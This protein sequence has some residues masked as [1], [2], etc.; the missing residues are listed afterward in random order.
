MPIE[1]RTTGQV[2]RLGQACKPWCLFLAS[3]GVFF[4]FSLA[5]AE[6]QEEKDEQNSEQSSPRVVPPKLKHFEEAK[7]PEGFDIADSPKTVLLSLEISE[8]GTINKVEVLES[9]GPEFDDAAVYAA[10]GFVFEPARV[11]GKAVPVRIKYQYIFEIKEKVVKEKKLIVESKP[12]AATTADDEDEVD[13]FTATAQVDQ[14]REVTKRTIESEVLL[15][16]PGTRGDALR[17]VELLPGVGRPPFSLGQLIVRGAAPG[18]SQTQLESLPIPLL[19][20]FGGLTS[21]IQPRL[22]KQID[23]YPGN[24]S[25]RFG[26]RTGGILDVTLRDPKDDALHGM[27]DLNIID[28]SVMLEGPVGKKGSFAAAARRSYIDLVLDA[29][30]PEGDV[31]IVAAPVY[32]DYQGLFNYKVS[33][34]DQLRLLVYGSNDTLRLLFQDPS[35]GDPLI[36]GNFGIQTSFHKLQG[37]WIHQYSRRT[38]HR[39]DLSAG[40]VN[41][42]FNVGN[43]IS[44]NL[45]SVEILGRSEW[46]TT[47]TKRLRIISGLDIRLQPSEFAYTGAQPTQQEGDPGNTV[48]GGDPVST[49]DLITSKGNLFIYEPAAY[50]TLDLLP[51]DAL[52]VLLSLRLDYFGWLDRWVFDPRSVVRYNLTDDTVIKA[53]VGLYSQPPQPQEGASQLGNPGLLGIRSMHLSTGVEQKLGKQYEVGAEL[54]YKYLWDRVVGTVGSLPPYFTNDG[55]GRIYGLELSGKVNPGGNFFGFLSYTLSRSERRDR[56]EQWRLFDFDQTH[57]LTVSGSYK[58]GEGWEAGATFRLVTGNPYTPITAAIY[59]ANVDVYQPIYG[60][61]NTKRNPMFHRL[62]VRIEKQ[63]LFRYWKLAA[64]LDVQ[65]VYN[66]MNPE[67]ILYSFDYS[68]TGVVSGLPII[69]S[70]GM[71][72]EF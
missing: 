68:Q 50:L 48:G 20:H 36:Q 13:S 59:N 51:L 19:Y 4:Q 46:Q 56:G 26:R 17:A 72:G 32:W 35:E 27:A 5:A 28:A 10:M 31:S 16:V 71:R 21:V 63:W 67:G 1:S 3:F 66:R 49:Q 24:F 11:N 30:V 12:A 34:R 43:D 52:Q 15:K 37:S 39:I 62:D 9:A 29:V 8:L 57:I 65:N 54:F 42:A 69:P 44:F 55:T 64:Y 23:F 33:R 60:R 6:A 40:L 14:P 53:G 47:V 58:L 22:L 2:P 38:Q 7:Y 25:A 61:T 41:L 18:D 45:D 70:L